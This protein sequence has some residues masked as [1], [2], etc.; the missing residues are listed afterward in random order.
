[1]AQ[2]ELGGLKEDL[3][4]DKLDKENRLKEEARKKKDKQK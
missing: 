1:M 3:L 2:D 4:L